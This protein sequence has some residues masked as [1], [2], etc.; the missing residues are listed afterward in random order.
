MVYQHHLQGWDLLDFNRM[1]LCFLP[2]VCQWGHAAFLFLSHLFSPSCPAL[3]AERIFC[4]F[5]GHEKS[6]LRVF[7][8]WANQN[9]YR[10]LKRGNYRWRAVDIPLYWGVCVCV[11]MSLIWGC[12]YVSEC[13]IYGWKR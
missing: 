3:C 2:R 11:C 9:F 6:V 4:L 13:I 12:L 8:S 10:S 5:R 1:R 7:V